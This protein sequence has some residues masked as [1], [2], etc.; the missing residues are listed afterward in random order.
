MR[1]VNMNMNNNNN[2]INSRIK[3]ITFFEL[4]INILILIPILLFFLYLKQKES[5]IILDNKEYKLDFSPINMKEDEK[6]NLNFR[7]LNKKE[8]IRKIKHKHLLNTLTKN[9]FY[10]KWFSKPS[11]E[12]VLLIGESISGLAEVKFVNAI[13]LE[14]KEDALCIVVS[15]I[16]TRSMTNLLLKEHGKLIYIMENYFIRKYRKDIL[17]QLIL[18]FLF[19]K[20]T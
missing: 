1:I 7:N 6:N 3:I 5:K 8:I 10:G 20:K 17:A 19:R 15:N 14:T 12:K 2:N 16:M 13:H 11:E 4:C 18:L 9:K